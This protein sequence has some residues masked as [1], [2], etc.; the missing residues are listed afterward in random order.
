MKTL[1]RYVIRNFL[2]SVGLWLVVM[3]ALRI[4]AD[5]F[6]NMDEFTER[7]K[8]VAQA[9]GQIFNYYRYHCLT[10]FIELGG[11][12]IVAGATFSLARMNQ[13]NELTAM[14]ASG[15]NLHRIILPIILLAAMMDGL[16]IVDQ[17]LLIPSYTAQLAIQRGGAE[18]T[19]DD[20]V[21]PL[22]DADRSIWR[23]ARFEP[24]RQ[25]MDNPVVVIRDKKSRPVAGLSGASATPA[26]LRGASGW[27]LERPMITRIIRDGVPWEHMPD[28]RRIWTH[29][30]PTQLLEE[31]RRVVRERTGQPVAPSED[32][33]YVEFVAPVGDAHY[34]LI[35]QAGRLDMIDPVKPGQAR[36]GKLFDATFAFSLADGRSLGTFVADSATWHP[37]GPGRGGSWQLENGRLFYATDLTANYII[38]RQSRRWM[39]YMSTAQLSEMLK[40]QRVATP[41]AILT[42][43][44]RFTEPLN[45]IIML[46]LT[47]PF[48]VS[49]ER[50]IKASASRCLLAAGAFYLFVYGCRYVG[51]PPAWAAW[52]PILLFGPIAVVML[53]SVKT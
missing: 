35:I 29:T 48:I 24:G 33:P 40:E 11:I 20:P 47:V 53:D 45:S 8:G 50:T 16:V 6:V 49:R 5:L 9:L 12:S 46:L 43:H 21:G 31:A 37:A 7:G 26:V 4:V 27:M 32:I 38:L 51:L 23:A 14:L 22:S 28:Y 36:G 18:E 41:Q 42:K 15:V 25:R 13:T 39:N 17:E 10:Y 30:G 1:D 52:L 34:Q 2:Y 44:T 19:R 3:M